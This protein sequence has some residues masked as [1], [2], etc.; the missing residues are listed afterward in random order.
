MAFDEDLLFTHRGLSGPAV[1]QI[2]S[3]WQEGTPLAINLAP[4]VDLPAALAQ[5]KAR[6]RKLIANELATLVPSRLA[7]TWAQREAD[8]QRPINE[9]T[10][11]AL[12][13]LAAARRP[14]VRA[15]PLLLQLDP[16][17]LILPLGALPVRLEEG[18]DQGRVLELQP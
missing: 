17:N 9:A 5:A 16:V 3:Y 7:D 13:R 10:D 18:G 6:S 2:S 14:V 11:K 12:A 4:T 15:N 8:W 1:L